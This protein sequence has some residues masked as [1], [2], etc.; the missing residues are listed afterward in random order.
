MSLSFIVAM[1]SQTN[2]IGYQG[3]MAWH[4]P[5]DL[6]FFKEKTLGKNVVMGRNSYHLL[7]KLPNRKLFALSNKDTPIL[8]TPNEIQLITQA[9]LLNSSDEFILAGGATLLN[10]IDESWLHKIKG[11]WITHITF[12]DKSIECDAFITKFIKFVET[13]FDIKNELTLV[14]NENFEVIVKEY[15]NNI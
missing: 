14:N 7:P 15:R 10:N 3:Q 8:N 6:K 4:I 12:K 5:E 2:G 1:D 9:E 13:H 11:G